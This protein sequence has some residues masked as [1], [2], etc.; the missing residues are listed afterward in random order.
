MT[1][2]RDAQGKGTAAGFCPSC[3]FQLDSTSSQSLGGKG[4]YNFGTTNT[5]TRRE[6]GVSEEKGGTIRG[7]ERRQTV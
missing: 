1:R 7:E 4:E 6:N 3:G 2:K 5:S